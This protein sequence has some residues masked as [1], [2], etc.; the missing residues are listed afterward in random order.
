MPLIC[1]C[2]FCSDHSRP[3]KQLFC[4]LTHPL[5]HVWWGCR[6]MHASFHLMCYLNIK[7]TNTGWPCKWAGLDRSES[8]G[9]SSQ[10]SGF[11]EAQAMRILCSTKYYAVQ[12]N[13]FILSMAVF[14][15]QLYSIFIALQ[16]AK[17]MLETS[18]LRVDLI[19]S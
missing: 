10:V 19:I 2:L 9:Q 3:V 17:C 5:T 8:G 6:I 7:H 16:F 11:Q 4:R 18:L 1:S 13:F 12:N 15:L 14:P